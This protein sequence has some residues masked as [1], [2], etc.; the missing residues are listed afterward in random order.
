MQPHKYFQKFA[1]AVVKRS[2]ISRA[3]VEAVLP[4]VFDEMRYQLTEGSLCVPV[5]GF[6]TLYVKDVPEHEYLYNRDG[7]NR[8]C[9]VPAK[10]QIK[11]APTRNLT[12]E[13]NSGQFDQSR[14]SFVRMPGDPMLRKRH[15]M[16]YKPAKRYNRAE[17]AGSRP[18]PKR[19]NDG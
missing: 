16:R 19:K 3:T 9:I 15:D 12:D 6:G 14:R 8:V 10:K 7:A 2:G 11:F 5:E 4:H 17:G 18:I 1:A 13:V